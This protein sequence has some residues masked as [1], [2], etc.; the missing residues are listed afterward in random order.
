M[1]DVVLSSGI[2]GCQDEDDVD[3]E[4]VGRVLSVASGGGLRLFERGGP[5][6]PAVAMTNDAVSSFCE[7]DF[8]NRAY[9][10]LSSQYRS[11][12]LVHAWAHVSP[13]AA[14]N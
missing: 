14:T 4:E 3:E 9:R 1:L 6:N 11:T 12:R 8:T 2:F 13:N 5:R 7:G 10:T